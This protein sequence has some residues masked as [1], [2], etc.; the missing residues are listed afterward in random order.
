MY[1]EIEIYE[2][3]FKDK[4]LIKNGD[5]SMYAG[6][7]IRDIVQLL[8]E[9]RSRIEIQSAISGKHS[10]KID[11]ETIDDIVDHRINGFLKGK[12]A[13]SF[14]KITKLFNPGAI[15]VPR[16]LLTI[17][18]PAWFYSILAVSFILNICIYAF[19]SRFKVSTVKEGIL[20]YVLLFAVLI[21]HE[22][23]HALAAR[24]YNTDVKEIGF[25]LYYVVPVFY[26]DLNEAWKLDRK[27]RMLIN[28]SGIFIQ[29]ILGIF[30]FLLG[31]IF[32]ESVNVLMSLFMVNFII[33]ILNLNPF[34]KFDGYWIAS[35]LFNEND[36]TRT[37]NEII[38]N[39]FKS[40]KNTRRPLLV[41]YS[42]LRLVF[43]GW[44]LF[45]IT[46]AAVICIKK[47]ITGVS[48]EWY[49]YLPVFIFL[50]IS[51]RIFYNILNKK[52]ELRK[53]KKDL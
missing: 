46:R 21:I 3:D 50:F 40:G 7:I 9:G 11:I 23:G 49:N 6:H 41:I 19:S 43:V 53:R 15:P 4:Y 51:Y 48:M 27:K 14:F 29:L 22:L 38:R 45:L 26:V 34:L 39:V 36:L 37:S 17:F 32:K 30:I 24:K 52:N 47:I 44:I 25:G 16:K 13:N 2:T 12:K 8:K 18:E 33:I 28:F 1:T 10:K 5:K 20:V 42:F 35:D 31:F